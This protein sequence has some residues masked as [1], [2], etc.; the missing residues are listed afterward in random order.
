MDLRTPFINEYGRLRSGWR[1]IV[2]AASFVAIILLLS[3]G[4][5]IV[6]VIGDATG[7]RIPHANFVAD[8]IY[9]M[10][11]LASA[12]GAGYLC[13]R[14]LEGLPWRSLGL[15]LQTRWFLDF[16]VGSMIG[17]LSLAL[18]VGI[19]AAAGGLRFTIG[20][21]DLLW[22]VTKSVGSSA[23]LFVVAA[24]AEEAM[25]RGYALQTLSRAK[26]AWLGIL[27]TSV[28]FAMVHLWNPNVVRGVTFINTAL[29]GVWLAIAYLR[30]RSLWLPL[31]VH[32]SWNWA[33]GSLFGLPVSGLTLV[34]HP[35]LQ[36]TDFGPAWITG[37]SYGIEGGTACT[38]ALVVSTLF[39]L[40]TRL[41]SA[42]P[43]LLKLTSEENPRVPQTPGNP[44]QLFD[45]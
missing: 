15:T 22:A 5:R 26:L 45:A 7:F 37:G 14:V 16:L 43:E 8:V 19:A 25:F 6:Y 44:V 2:F 36:G 41:V 34:S 10:L 39:L 21:G 4:L 11:L 33:L 9:R 38:I 12:L 35:L 24:L 27:I 13:S 31:G 18:A 23:V 29:A 1:L 40:R 17:L 30:T 28:P 42:T 32:W 3:T 20:G